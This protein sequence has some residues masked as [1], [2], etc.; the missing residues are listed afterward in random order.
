MVPEQTLLR[1]ERA[2]REYLP[3]AAILSFVYLCIRTVG[4][5]Q[6]SLHC[7]NN[8]VECGEIGVVSVAQWLE[9]WSANRRDCS[10]SL[11]TYFF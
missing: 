6:H 4:Q 10:P 9:R 3:G 2:L 11:Q 1:I 8:A 7:D 5:R